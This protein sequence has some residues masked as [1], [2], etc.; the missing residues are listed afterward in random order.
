MRPGLSVVVVALFGTQ[1]FAIKQKHLDCR[2]KG[3]TGTVVSHVPG[4]GGDVWFVKHYGSEEIAAYCIN[5]IEENKAQTGDSDV[6]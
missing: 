4:H 5:E 6:Q 1:G 3:A 2:R